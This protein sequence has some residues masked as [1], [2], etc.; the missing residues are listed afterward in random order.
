[1]D[2]PNGDRLPGANKDMQIQLTSERLQIEFE[3]YER[4][5]AVRIDP[6]MDIPLAHISSV[7]TAEPNSNWAEI[8]APGTF[9]PGIIK[10]GTYYTKQGKEF[11]YVTDDRNYLTLEL[12]DEP[13]RR[14]A[15]TLPDNRSWHDRIAERI[16]STSNA[17]H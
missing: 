15:M 14:L 10:A 6:V 7:T 2:V 3:W 1:M 16:G 13:Y 11:W 5:W 12:H 4:L 8:R 9:L 17:S